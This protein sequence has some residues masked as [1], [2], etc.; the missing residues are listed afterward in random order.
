MDIIGTGGR[1]M[2]APLDAAVH[3]NANS[4]GLDAIDVSDP[5]LYQDDVWYPYFA[6]LRR[7]DPVHYCPESLYGPYWAVTK[8]KDIM[9]VEV[10]HAIYSSASELGGIQIEDPQ[11]HGATELYSHGSAAPRRPTQGRQPDRGPRQSG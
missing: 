3:T 8:Y 6:R 5:R 7:D 11:G 10:N 9:Q 1:S 2:N 4:V